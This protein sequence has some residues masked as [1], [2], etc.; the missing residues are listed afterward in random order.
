MQLNK[1]LK[2]RRQFR[3]GRKLITAYLV[4]TASAVM[5]A[6]VKAQQNAADTDGVI[7]LEE[8]IR[9][10]QQ[11]PRVLSIVPWD[12]PAHKR[13]GRVAL[14]GD[15]T[16]FMEPLERSAFLQRVALHQALLGAATSENTQDSAAN[17][18]NK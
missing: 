14:T 4:V 15:R 8:T 13:I 12:S 6:D 10:D 7:R 11:Q 5:I 2:G 1:M 3:R 16:A 18:N 9:G 17:E